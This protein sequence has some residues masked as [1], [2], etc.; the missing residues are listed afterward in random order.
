MQSN[1]ERNKYNKPVHNKNSQNTKFRVLSQI[2]AP[3]QT[4]KTLQI[5][6]KQ[7]RL[8]CK[9]AWTHKLNNKSGTS[10]ALNAGINIFSMDK[11][12]QHLRSISIKSMVSV[13]VPVCFFVHSFWEKMRACQYFHLKIRSK[14]NPGSLPLQ[15]IIQG[16]YKENNSLKFNNRSSHVITTQ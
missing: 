9:P 7:C 5:H 12:Q 15:F 14:I 2:Q 11:H 8:T 6:A 10:N 1:L 16:H 13:C 3:G 4:C